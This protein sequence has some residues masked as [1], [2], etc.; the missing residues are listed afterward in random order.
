MDTLQIANTILEQLGGR[1]FC[2]MTGSKN[3]MADGNSLIMTLAANKIKAK[4]LR[5]ILDA[6]DTYIM[7]FFTFNKDLKKTVLERV[8]DVYCDQLQEVF[9]RFTGLYTRL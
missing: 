2:I 1:R 8:E 6:S 9:T 4:R 3:F 5:I 7:E